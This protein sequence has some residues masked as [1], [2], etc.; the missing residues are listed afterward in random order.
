MGAGAIFILLLVLVIAG[1]LLVMFTG[2]GTSLGLR[3][4][5]SGGRSDR[6]ATGTRTRRPGHTK[7]EDDASKEGEPRP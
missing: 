1:T 3:A 5:R 6:S 7:V 4:D 2:L